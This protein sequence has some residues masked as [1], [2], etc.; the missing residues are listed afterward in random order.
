MHV[1]VE[2]GI[3]NRRY[4]RIFEFLFRVGDMADFVF[5]YHNYAQDV[6]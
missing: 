4:G 5:P 2:D 3:F 1:H 6:R